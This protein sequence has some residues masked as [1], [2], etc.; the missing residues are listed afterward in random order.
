MRDGGDIDKGLRT[1]ALV[2]TVVRRGNELLDS[3]RQRLAREQPFLCECSAIE[4]RSTVALTAQEYLAV[5]ANDAAFVVSPGREVADLDHVIARY[6]T[7]TVVE[8]P[9]L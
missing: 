9:A 4:C 5:R 6:E 3:S 1:L 7:Y 8:K 2:E